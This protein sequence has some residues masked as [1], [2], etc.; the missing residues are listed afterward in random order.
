M[1]AQAVK[2]FETARF[3]YCESARLVLPE[4]ILSPLAEY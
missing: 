3:I 4:E 2:V 1:R